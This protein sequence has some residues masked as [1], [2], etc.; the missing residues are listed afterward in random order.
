MH[1]AHDPGRLHVSAC[2]FLFRLHKL[3]TLGGS[4][5]KPHCAQITYYILHINKTIFEKIQ[6]FPESVFV[7]HCLI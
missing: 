5:Q 1:H 2:L 3:L 7:L 4:S 6:D